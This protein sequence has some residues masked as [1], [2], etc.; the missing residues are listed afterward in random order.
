MVTGRGASSAFIEET[1]PQREVFALIG[2]GLRADATFKLA[3]AAPR[4]LA[5]NALVAPQC[6]D[7]RGPGGT[8]GLEPLQSHINDSSLPVISF[9]QSSCRTHPRSVV[10]AYSC[11][12]GRWSNGIHSDSFHSLCSDGIH[13]I[14]TIRGPQC[15]LAV[16]NGLLPSAP[17]FP[18]QCG[19][20]FAAPARRDISQPDMVRPPLLRCVKQNSVCYEGDK[21]C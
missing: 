7:Q 17:L 5:E 14:R 11:G 10:P 2:P 12:R 4:R 21:P 20:S 18:V 1:E 9:P 3:S 13:S 19:T 15:C 6:H 16:T 8:L